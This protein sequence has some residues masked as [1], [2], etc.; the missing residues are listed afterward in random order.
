MSSLRRQFDISIPSRRLIRERWRARTA[1]VNPH[2]LFVFGN[3]KSGTTALAGLL[4]EATGRTATLDFAGAWGR[5]AQALIAGRT[6]VAGFV[7]RNAW[8]FAA[9]IIKEPNLT[10]AAPQLMAH[11]PGAR[12]IFMVRDPCANIRS[13]L[14][15]LRLSGDAQEIAPKDWRRIGP[16][17]RMIL[18]GDD[19]G[20]SGK[21]HIEI[22]AR[23]WLKAADM[24]DGIK[25]RVRLVRYE[26]FNADKLGVISALA[27]EFALPVTG[28]ISQSLNR[29]FQPRAPA[30]W[31]PLEFF[32]RRNLD[33]IARICAARATEFGYRI[34]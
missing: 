12:A 15:R 1:V 21:D 31:S 5:R 13:I 11:F 33:C 26:D 6:P 19:I 34:G 3:Q 28:D 16:N 17:W 23:R 9:D 27:G 22:L 29:D 20:V 8:A 30:E 32:G 2:P 18:R 25:A 7:R 24:R 10:F 14:V 4:A